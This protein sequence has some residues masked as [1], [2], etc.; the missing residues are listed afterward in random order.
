[1]NKFERVSKFADNENIQLP[2]RATKY[3]AGYDFYAADTITVPSYKR[4]METLS[5]YV[6]IKIP[7]GVDEFKQISKAVKIKPTLV[8]TGIKCKL[9]DGY[10][11]ELAI[12]S[13]VP[14]NNWIVLAN[15]VGV[16]DKDYYDNPDN[17]GE[18]FFQ[19]INLSPVDQIIRFG[20]KI[21]QGIIKRYYTVE[22]DAA[23]GERLGGF[24]STTNE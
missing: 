24:G 14:L 23:D 21:G 15:G 12:R 1:M 19:V 11:L 22:D 13:S 4:A 10:Y 17:E 16:I 6:A 9:D 2:I 7:Y 18:I 5:D 20:E 8:P 3:S